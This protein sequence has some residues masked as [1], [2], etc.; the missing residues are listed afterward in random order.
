MSRVSP[1]TVSLGNIIF[2]NQHGF[3]PSLTHPDGSKNPTQ[4]ATDPVLY[5]F[6]PPISEETTRA[7]KLLEDMEITYTSRQTKTAEEV[8]KEVLAGRAPNTVLNKSRI[9][10]VAAAD[11]DK[12][13]TKAL[14]GLNAQLSVAR[15]KMV[16]WNAET[17]QEFK[18]WFGPVTLNQR[19]IILERVNATARIAE[20][21]SV[22]N[23]KVADPKHLPEGMSMNTVFA[24]VYPSDDTTIYLGPKF[25]KAPLT[26]SDSKVGTLAHE[27]SHFTSVAGT[28]DHVYG[29]AAS[30]KLAQ[31]D[32]IR[33]VHDYGEPN[34]EWI[35][36]T[37]PLTAINNADSF[38][39]FIEGIQ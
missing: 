3:I 20:G 30:E 19:R 6:P 24:Y 15:K 22:D 29:E 35:A 9:P 14:A 39:Y 38:Q 37:F 33:G 2:A 5:F 31:A 17:Q 13:I 21:L 1:E 7:R 11:A 36:K 16:E 4:K 12:Q 34:E 23:F 25:G 8:I 18:K 10:G 27:I 32:A 28:D 26:G